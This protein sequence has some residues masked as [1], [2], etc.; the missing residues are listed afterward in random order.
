MH[1][2]M[3]WK[4]YFHL[5][6]L[7]KLLMYKNS[8]DIAVQPQHRWVHTLYMFSLSDLS[9]LSCLDKILYMFNF[10]DRIEEENE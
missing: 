4:E 10:E 3:F 2:T 9:L 6:A 1:E 7:T 5:V 8:C